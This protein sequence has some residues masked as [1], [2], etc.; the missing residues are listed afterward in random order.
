MP[1]SAWLR[2]LAFLLQTDDYL[3]RKFIPA[4][5]LFELLPLLFIAGIPGE[6]QELAILP[7]VSTSGRPALQTSAESDESSLSTSEINL[8]GSD[9]QEI[10]GQMAPFRVFQNG[11]SLFQG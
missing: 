8:S 6:G 5:S 11:A 7:P 10:S 9:S 4:I 3:I 2:R 1:P